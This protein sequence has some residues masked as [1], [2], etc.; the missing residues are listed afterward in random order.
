MQATA[1]RTTYGASSPTP[2]TVTHA[3][4]TSLRL[5]VYARHNGIS[6][7]RLDGGRVLTGRPFTSVVVLMVQPAMQKVLPHVTVL[8]PQDYQSVVCI[9]FIQ[10]L[11][12]CTLVDGGVTTR[13]PKDGHQNRTA[14]LK[15]SFPISVRITTW[16][17]TD[18]L[19]IW[20]VSILVHGQSAYRASIFVMSRDCRLP[21]PGF[22]DYPV[23]VFRNAL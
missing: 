4:D 1:C 14:S 16:Q 10:C 17:A 20:Q 8:P 21:A 22:S 13:K 6:A 23:A 19:D 18:I 15:T 3:H 2:V 9:P 7:I 12:R 11:C 5:P